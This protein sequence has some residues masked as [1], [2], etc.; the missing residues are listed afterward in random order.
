M[1][2]VV[3][4][5]HY[6]YGILWL[7]VSHILPTLWL[8]AANTDVTQF[9]SDIKKFVQFTVVTCLWLCLWHLCCFSLWWFKISLFSAFPMCCLIIVWL[10]CWQC[11]R[12]MWMSHA[13]MWYKS[14][15]E[16][17][18]TTLYLRNDI[19]CHLTWRG[20]RHVSTHHCY[21]LI[22]CNTF[23]DFFL[24]IFVIYSLKVVHGKQMCL[25]SHDVSWNSRY[26]VVFQHPSIYTP[27]YA[28]RY[29]YWS[30]LRRIANP[31]LWNYKPPVY[32]QGFIINNHMMC[33]RPR[34]ST[35]AL[36]MVSRKMLLDT[37]E[38]L[39]Q[40]VSIAWSGHPL[41]SLPLYCTYEAGRWG[42][43]ISLHQ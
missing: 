3:L 1:T 29:L 38:T 15:V 4:H 16:L 18:S 5:W 31:W 2:F 11:L 21:V 12:Y 39:T 36:I 28:C 20:H 10:P 43:Y 42:H 23:L 13:V 24:L 27:I 7:R 8:N 17:F 30:Y 19:Y 25:Y 26:K 9:C 22:F 32:Y 37:S 34:C 40:A 41:F 14:I 33:V 6:I 35:T